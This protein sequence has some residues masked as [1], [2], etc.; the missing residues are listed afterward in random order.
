MDAGL[1][2]TERHGNIAD[3]TILPP[4]LWGDEVRAL[5]ALYFNQR[6]EPEVSRP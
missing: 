5:C 2:V 1:S 3:A 4:Y 6:L